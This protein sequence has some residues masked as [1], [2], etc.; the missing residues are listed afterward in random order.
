M[1]DFGCLQTKNS[2]ITKFFNL[3]YQAFILICRPRFLLLFCTVLSSSWD[4]CPVVNTSINDNPKCACILELL[5]IIVFCKPEFIFD[6]LVTLVICG[7]VLSFHNHVEPLTYHIYL[8][9]Q[10]AFNII[11]Y[12]L[13]YQDLTR[14]SYYKSEL[15]S[16]P[17]KTIAFHMFV[18]H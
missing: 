2:W 14:T 5:V 16:D 18:A 15:I 11:H 17:W 9:N 4:T 6:L 13:R 10:S 12:S 3:H 8:T 1:V 7:T